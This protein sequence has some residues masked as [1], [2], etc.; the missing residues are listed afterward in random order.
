MKNWWSYQWQQMIEQTTLHI[1]QT[2]YFIFTIQH[3]TILT[4]QGSCRTSQRKNFRML[5][6][7]SPA[8]SHNALYSPKFVVM[9]FLHTICSNSKAS[10]HWFGTS[11]WES[12]A[13]TKT[14]TPKQNYGGKKRKANYLSQRIS[15]QL[16]ALV[17]SCCV[18]YATSHKPVQCQALCLTT[19]IT[20]WL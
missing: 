2:V 1:A 15:K 12:V 4:R 10:H 16:N 20:F 14:T 19:D 5:K 8:L 6:W 17:Q 18:C 7:Q 3:T 13:H 11:L 9:Y